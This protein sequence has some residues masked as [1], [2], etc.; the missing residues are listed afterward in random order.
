MGLLVSK[1]HRVSLQEIEALPEPEPQGR[2]H[3][4]YHLAEVVHTL[5][6][7][8][9]ENGFGVAGEDYALAKKDGMLLGVLQL[10]NEESFDLGGLKAKPALGFRSSVNK[11]SALW[12]VGGGA[13]MVCDNMMLSGEV[14]MVVRKHTINMNL[15]QQVRNGFNNYLDQQNLLKQSVDRLQQ[16]SLTDDRAKAIVYDSIINYDIP[17]R[18]L[19]DVNKWYFEKRP[20]DC[21]PRTSWGLHNSFTRALKTSTAFSQF[22]HTRTIGK[23]FGLGRM[24]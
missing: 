21:D 18:L 6:R 8:A 7:V 15:L 22:D 10:E 13:V 24:N 12:I 3:K 14:V 5:H 23:M 9:G 1:G 17:G 16:E 4:P 19:K 11:S 20:E 2:W